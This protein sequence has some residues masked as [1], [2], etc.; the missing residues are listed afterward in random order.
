MSRFWWVNHKQTFVQERGGGYLWSPKT[1]ANGARSEYYSNMRRARAGDQVVSYADG[2]V[3]AIGLVA[4]EAVEAPKPATFGSVGEYWSLSGWLLPVA[5]RDVASEVRP[6][7]HLTIIAPLLPAKY[8]P[9]NAASGGGNQK[10]YL[11]E[12]S[13]ALFQTIIGLTGGMTGE[14]SESCNVNDVIALQEEAEAAA[15]V[16][17]ISL[18]DTEK[19]AIIAARHGQGEFRRRL[20]ERDGSCVVTEVNDSRLLRASH[21]KPW[22]LC[23]TGAE[24]LDVSNGLLLTPTLDQLFDRGLI[25]FFQ[26]GSVKISKSLMERD[27]VRLGLQALKARYSLAHH[28]PYLSFHRQEVFIQ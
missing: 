5:W 1:E 11:S 8:S 9:L 23:K 17:D 7:A 2:R 16:N 10:A 22:R 26:D 4:S 20:L 14:R 27:V 25:T 13:E 15:I 3:R 24:R 21:I 28:E 6:S 19:L 18:S 12:I